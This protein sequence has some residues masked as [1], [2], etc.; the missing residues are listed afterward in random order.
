[1]LRIL[2]RLGRLFRSA[3]VLARYDVLPPPEWADV[4]PAPL[5]LAARLL[6]R[7]R[8]LAKGRSGERLTKARTDLGPSFIKAGQFLARTSSAR[9]SRRT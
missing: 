7:A 2:T 9:K 4:T 6:P 8:S 1:M 3:R 5:R